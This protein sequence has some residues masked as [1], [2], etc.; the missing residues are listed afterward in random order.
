MILKNFFKQ[1]EKHSKI[2]SNELYFMHA[3]DRDFYFVL[4]KGKFFKH[5]HRH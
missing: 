4:K 2:N 5:L 3:K 1:I